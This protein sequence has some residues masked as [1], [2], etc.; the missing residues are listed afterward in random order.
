MQN[1]N[2]ITTVTEYDKAW[3]DKFGLV[4]GAYDWALKELKP[5]HRV[6]GSRVL[7]YNNQLGVYNFDIRHHAEKGVTV[8]CDYPWRCPA[9][10]RVNSRQMIIQE[11][12][13]MEIVEKYIPCRDETG[14]MVW[15]LWHR[16]VY[17]YHL[18][19]KCPAINY[20]LF[21]LQCNEVVSQLAREANRRDWFNDMKHRVMFSDMRNDTPEVVKPLLATLA[22]EA[23]SILAQAHALG[24]GTPAAKSRA[25]A[26]YTA[27][28]EYS[29]KFVLGVGGGTPFRRMSK[30]TDKV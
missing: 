8:E 7:P 3:T 4:S 15:K 17:E 16:R 13:S 28:L 1:E 21:L 10:M 9:V 11:L 30:P 26:G 25:L 24:P 14:K 20:N 22:E 12:G 27:L 29:T 18:E 6:I 23:R 19:T 2:F 5:G